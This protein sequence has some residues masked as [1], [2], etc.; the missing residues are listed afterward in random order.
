MTISG[1]VLGKIACKIRVGCMDVYCP[2]IGGMAQT[3][4]RLS[5]VLAKERKKIWAHIENRDLW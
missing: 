3:Y 2:F 1:T 4:E 5:L